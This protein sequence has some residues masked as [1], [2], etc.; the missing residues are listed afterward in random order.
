VPRNLVG[1]TNEVGKVPGRIRPVFRDRDDLSSVADLGTTV[2]QALADSE[3]LIV[4]CSPRAAASH[5]VNEEIRHF[6]R[7]DRAARIFCIIVGGGPAADGSVAA[8]FP[9][10]LAEAGMA[11][12]LAAD[13]RKWADGKKVAKLKLI[14]GLLGIRLD[15]LRR[16][17]L[18][19]QRKQQVITGLGVVV[20]VSLITVTTVARIS[21]RHE[22]E[23]TEQLATFIVDLGE[24][25]QSDAD[26]ET[27]ALISTE[28]LKHLQGMD[29]DKLSLET[30][31][32]VALAL[33]QMGK[34]SQGQ[35]RPVQAL[36]AFGRSRD[37][38]LRLARKYPQ[39]QD[40][41]FQLGN[42]EFYIG[43]LHLEQ[44]HYKRALVAMKSYQKLTRQLFDMDPENPDWIMELAYSYNNIAALQ[45]ESGL[46]IDKKTL[47]FI[48]ES[49][50]LMEKVVQ[51][52]P[53]DKTVT[54]SYAS[55]LAWA[56]DAQAQVCNLQDA[57]VLRERV[58]SLA[59]GSAQSD[60]G[61]ND[62]NRRFAYSLSGVARLQRQLG[63]LELA[64]QSLRRSIAILGQLSAADPSN[65]TNREQAAIQK[66][67]LAKLLQDSGQPEAA[68]ATM[69]E[70][71]A[72]KKATGIFTNQTGSSLN[73]FID[74]LI[75]FADI[76]FRTGHAAKANAYLKQALE[77]Q[78]DRAVLQQW[79]G[80]DK[81]QL[82]KTRYQWWEG[83]GHDGLAAFSIPGGT[84][85]HSAGEFQSCIE[86]DFEARM[87]MLEG[88]RET[89]VSLVNYL[90][91]QGYS[92]PGFNLFCVKYKLC[93]EES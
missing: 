73:G 32:K 70:L 47:Q 84:G 21:E 90:K 42:A 82:Q 60:P 81:V 92:D 4:V 88:D 79:V 56:A 2:K 18:Q 10:A 5:W 6:A 72:E 12:P 45:L 19:R 31:E 91:N 44:G 3:N 11:E 62:L 17:E 7:L 40:L 28:A 29:L 93:K 80:F 76:E 1:D 15:K 48:A 24:R 33:R 46:G 20:A 43:S 87:F 35:G 58:K 64:E 13:V 26:L 50:K 66:V 36:D 61:N 54:D 67:A 63:Q 38:F 25:L 83:N 23:K 69:Q 30:G 68:R 51:L 59:E 75:V 34:V 85:Q 41:L 14:A 9:A 77:L 52:R 55:T 78:L 37:L 39:K 22:R 8:C 49:V 16:R 27:L 53:D 65:V 89:A 57:M 86:S 74:Y 71:V